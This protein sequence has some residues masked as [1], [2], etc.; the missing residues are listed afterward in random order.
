MRQPLEAAARLCN[1]ARFIF[2]E[3]THFSMAT[4]RDSTLSKQ[5]KMD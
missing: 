1:Q 3:Q 5:L 2:P 4:I